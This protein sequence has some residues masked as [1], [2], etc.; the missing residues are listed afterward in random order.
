MF[1]SK[2]PQSIYVDL[3]ALSSR[4]H[5]E[6][7]ARHLCLPLECP[8]VIDRVDGVRSCHLNPLVPLTLLLQNASNILSNGIL[9]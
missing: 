9:T 4:Y 7:A 3:F 1:V 8:H 6:I 2:D 5:G